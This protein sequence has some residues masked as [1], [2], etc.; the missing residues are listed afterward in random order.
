MPEES[1]N[2]FQKLKVGCKL[3]LVMNNKRFYF[4]KNA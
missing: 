2:P 1:K 4:D 3:I